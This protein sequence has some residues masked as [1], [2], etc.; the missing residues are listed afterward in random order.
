MGGEKKDL[1]ENVGESQSPKFSPFSPSAALPSLNPLITPSPRPSD[2]QNV[3]H[4]STVSGFIAGPH[5][6]HLETNRVEC[7]RDGRKQSG[8]EAEMFLYL[9]RKW[10]KKNK[11]QTVSKKKR[12]AASAAAASPLPPPP[13]ALPRLHWIPPRLP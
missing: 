13:P 6:T 1:L 8:A 10:Q 7:E 11:R 9:G 3:W 2:R 4:L 5:E 12:R